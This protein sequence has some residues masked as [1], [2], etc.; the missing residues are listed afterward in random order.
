[1]VVHAVQGRWGLR[2]P[3]PARA[4]G[5]HL[6]SM[7]AAA[8]EGIVDGLSQRFHLSGEGILQLRDGICEVTARG[9]RLEGRQLTKVAARRWHQG[10][11]LRAVIGHRDLLALEVGAVRLLGPLEGELHPHVGQHD[12]ARHA[13]L[14]HAAAQALEVLVHLVL[15]EGRLDGAGR[16]A[17]HQASPILPF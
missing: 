5:R 14:R 12:P 4:G 2:V 16:M 11:Q 10:A 7:E 13:V 1:M 9:R 15:A 6:L 8:V 3:G 17:G